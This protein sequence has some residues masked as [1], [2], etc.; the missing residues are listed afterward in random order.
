MYNSQD[1]TVLIAT[2][3]RVKE[4]E[5]AIESTLNQSI[6]ANIVILDDASKVNIKDK[7]IN[8]FDLLEL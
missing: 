1:I 8:K 6:A 7:L 3:D 5:R 2:K 4:I